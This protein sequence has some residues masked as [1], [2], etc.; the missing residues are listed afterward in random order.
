LPK[1]LED[2]ERMVIVVLE[3]ERDYQQQDR[4]DAVK[5]VK[6]VREMTVV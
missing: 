4:K 2:V 6:A 3:I 5:A 1:V